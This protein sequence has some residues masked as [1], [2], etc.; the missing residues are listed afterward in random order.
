MDRTH[1]MR[2]GSVSET[3]LSHQHSQTLGLTLHAHADSWL[4]HNSA[5]GCLDVT[6]GIKKA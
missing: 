6:L 3:I 4:L 5:I 1:L 2:N